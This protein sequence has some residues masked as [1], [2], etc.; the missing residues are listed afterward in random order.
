MLKDKYVVKSNHESGFGRYDICLIPKDLKGNGIVIELKKIWS[1]SH[2]VPEKS[3][4]KGNRSN[5]REKIC[6]SAL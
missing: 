6:P 3:R 1:D 4:S 5:H 2:E